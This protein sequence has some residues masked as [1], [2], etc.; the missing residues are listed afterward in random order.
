MLGRVAKGEM[1]LPVDGVEPEGSGAAGVEVVD[2]DRPFTE[3]N[4]RGFI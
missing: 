4:L 3:D 2:R 1:R